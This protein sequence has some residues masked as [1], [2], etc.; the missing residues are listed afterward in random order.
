[1]A[2]ARLTVWPIT[3]R[4]KTAQGTPPAAPADYAP[5][6]HRA[7]VSRPRRPSGSQTLSPGRYLLSRFTPVVNRDLAPLQFLALWGTTPSL[8]LVKLTFGELT[9]ISQFAIVFEYNIKKRYLNSICT[10]IIL[11]CSKNEVTW[12]RG[13]IFKMTQSA[14][15]CQSKIWF[16]SH[17]TA[18]PQ[19]SMP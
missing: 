16:I 11:R 4:P 13:W 18:C 12:P 5:H 1:M 6:P 14:D 19:N 15:F 9:Q 2:T 8:L 3:V 10:G 17:S 7:L